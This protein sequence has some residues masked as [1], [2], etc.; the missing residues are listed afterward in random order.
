MYTF[1]WF[2]REYTKQITR[3]T[4]IHPRIA[5]IRLLLSTG[6]YNSILS[7]AEN[8]NK[9]IKASHENVLQ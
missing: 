2:S 8:W 5:R 9:A 3:T 1:N 7:I 6:K 4:I